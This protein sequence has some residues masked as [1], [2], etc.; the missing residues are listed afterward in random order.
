M[1]PLAALPDF[2]ALSCPRSP[3]FRTWTTG[4]SARRGPPLPPRVRHRGLSPLVGLPAESHLRDRPPRPGLA[5]PAAR[6]PDRSSSSPSRSRSCRGPTSSSTTDSRSAGP[7]ETGLVL[8]VLSVLGWV[9]WHRDGP[10]RLPDRI[11]RPRRRW[12]PQP[13]RG[14]PRHHRRALRRRTGRGSHQIG[15]T[16]RRRCSR[17]C[18]GTTATSTRRR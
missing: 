15:R 8:M 2:D 10:R 16:R 1:S 14:R 11:G 12:Q 7:T 18:C 13:R 6:P 17:S 3:P 4:T 5:R 9:F